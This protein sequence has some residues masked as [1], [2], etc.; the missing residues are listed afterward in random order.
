MPGFSA[1]ICK[2]MPGRYF[3]SYWDCYHV[4]SFPRNHHLKFIEFN[5]QMQLLFMGKNI[6]H[7]IILWEGCS[8]TPL[9]NWEYLRIVWILQGNVCFFFSHHQKRAPGKVKNEYSSFY[10]S[11]TALWLYCSE[12]T[13]D[14]IHK[15]T[16]R[17][18]LS[19]LI[20][21]SCESVKMRSL[22]ILTWQCTYYCSVYYWYKRVC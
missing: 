3:W 18:E 20:L 7:A 22:W 10:L 16:E 15:Q 11:I 17:M 2:Q 1:I 8:T 14:V 4:R 9:R 6:F 13:S 5:P 21:H 19:F 12:I